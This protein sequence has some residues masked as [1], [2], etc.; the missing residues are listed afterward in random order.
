M[1][2]TKHTESTHKFTSTNHT[3]MKHAHTKHMHESVKQKH[4]QS[5][6]HTAQNKRHKHKARAKCAQTAHTKHMCTKMHDS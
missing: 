4:T 1:K 5:A 2:L 6:K 3:S